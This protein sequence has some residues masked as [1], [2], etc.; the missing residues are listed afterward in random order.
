[1]KVVVKGNFYFKQ[2][3]SRFLVMLMM[4]IIMLMMIM[5]IMMIMMAVLRKYWIFCYFSM[6]TYN[7]S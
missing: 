1:M 3:D 5:M 7:A 4:M 6:A 2:N